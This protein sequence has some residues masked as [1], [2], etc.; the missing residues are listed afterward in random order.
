[1]RLMR[2]KTGVLAG[3]LAALFMLGA[4]Q[5]AH[6]PLPDSKVFRDNSD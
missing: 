4:C 2:Q 1:M 5:A 3:L 6:T